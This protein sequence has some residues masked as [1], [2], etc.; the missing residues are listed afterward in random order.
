MACGH[1]DR[2]SGANPRQG[3]TFSRPAAQ[4]C[5]NSGL[6]CAMRSFSHLCQQA[7]QEQ[8]AIV[9]FHLCVE[10]ATVVC[11]KL[12]GLQGT[13]LHAR[14]GVESVGIALWTV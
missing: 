13:V 12:A 3:Q 6:R 5:C 9:S 8:P 14:C 4:T 1:A 7:Q 10:A 11:L 2:M